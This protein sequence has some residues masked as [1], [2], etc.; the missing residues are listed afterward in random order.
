[1]CPDGLRRD[2]RQNEEQEAPFHFNPNGD[3]CGADLTVAN[4]ERRVRSANITHGF[5]KLMKSDCCDRL[6]ISEN[7]C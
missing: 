3:C 1:M 7:R 6:R 2:P 4:R 5:P